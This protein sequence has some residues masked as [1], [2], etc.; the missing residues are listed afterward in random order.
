MV[1]NPPTC[2]ETPAGFERSFL[3]AASGQDP[4]ERKENI[5]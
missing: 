2:E 1:M 4:S 5:S 3:P